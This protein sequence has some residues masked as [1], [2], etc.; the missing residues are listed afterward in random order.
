MRVEAR[1]VKAMEKWKYTRT[2]H[3][4]AKYS[5]YQISRITHDTHSQF[6]YYIGGIQTTTCMKDATK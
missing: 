3:H 1:A 5:Y 4:T 6:R 2:N